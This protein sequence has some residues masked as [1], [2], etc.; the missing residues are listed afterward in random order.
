MCISYITLYASCGCPSDSFLERCDRAKRGHCGLPPQQVI[1]DA[2]ATS[3][4]GHYRDDVDKRICQQCVTVLKRSVHLLFSCFE[5]DGLK[6][7]SR[8]GDV[9]FTGGNEDW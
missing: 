1:V 9:V 6:V 7:R 5:Q 4:D 2:A 3:E 8:I